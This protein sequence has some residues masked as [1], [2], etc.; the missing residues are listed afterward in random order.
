MRL[1]SVNWRLLSFVDS[2]ILQKKGIFVFQT[3][4][5]VDFSTKEAL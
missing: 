5:P 3:A 2:L 4:V 1:I